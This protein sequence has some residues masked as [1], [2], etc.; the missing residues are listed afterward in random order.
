MTHQPGVYMPLRALFLFFFTFC[1]TDFFRNK[2]GSEEEMTIKI[3]FIQT[4]FQMN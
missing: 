3:K 1:F 4:I 2:L